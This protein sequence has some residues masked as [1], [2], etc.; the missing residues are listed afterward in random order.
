MGWQAFTKTSLNNAAELGVLVELRCRLPE[1]HLSN[2]NADFRRLQK[3]TNLI[4]FVFNLG[5]A[6]ACPSRATDHHTVSRKPPRNPHA[7]VCLDYVL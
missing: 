5:K 2:V 1:F 6:D 7:P 4:R 3:N